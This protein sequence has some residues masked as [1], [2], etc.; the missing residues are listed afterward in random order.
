[1]TGYSIDAAALVEYAR[2]HP[3]AAHYIIAGDWQSLVASDPAAFTVR[4][5]GGTGP[6]VLDVG[7]LQAAAGALTGNPSYSG[8]VQALQSGDPLAFSRGPFDVYRDTGPLGN[9]QRDVAV[10]AGGG[11][12][13]APAVPTNPYGQPY[14]APAHAGGQL[15]LPPILLLGALF[16]FLSRRRRR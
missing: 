2:S 14:T 6:I 11:I 10:S 16:A 3:N 9:L 5:G 7:V 4:N 12:T 13:V 1:M 8:M 15:K